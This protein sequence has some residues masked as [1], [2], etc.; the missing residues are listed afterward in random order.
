MAKLHQADST[1]IEDEAMY[2]NAL[3]KA[4]VDYFDYELA[5]RNG[6]RIRF[7]EAHRLQG[8]WIRLKG[9]K[10]VVHNERVVASEDD[11]RHGRFERGMDI[12]EEEIVWVADAPIGS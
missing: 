6:F 8:G 7:C 12:R 2:D 3:D 9:I 10:E 11:C 4:T 5:L 1:V